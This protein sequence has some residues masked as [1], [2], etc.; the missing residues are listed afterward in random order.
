M[1]NKMKNKTFTIVSG[2]LLLAGTS[3]VFAADKNGLTGTGEAAFSK[4]SGNTDEEKIYASLKLNYAQTA[5][6]IKGLLE[7]DSAKTG[8]TQT[9]ERYV[10]DFQG[11]KAFPT[12]PKLYGFGQ[13]RF[14]NDRFQAIDLSSS[15][16]AGLG[17]KFITEKDMTLTGEVGLGYQSINYNDDTSTEDFDQAITKLKADFTYQINESV[18][19]AQD[20]IV[21][22]GADQRKTEANTSLGVKMSTALSLKA[23]YKIRHNNTPATG[24]ENIDTDL[25]LGVIYDF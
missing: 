7:A 16:L 19:F 25:V 17:Y 18:N 21:I 15:Y 1:K 4:S 20:V 22:A 24:Q 3:A 23:T 6:K 14:E 12:M 5:Y 11:D 13:I 2:L 8:S 10:A 9:K